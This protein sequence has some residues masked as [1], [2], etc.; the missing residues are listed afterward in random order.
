MFHSLFLKVDDSFNFRFV[1][2]FSPFHSLL[3]QYWECVCV[4]QLCRNI[5]PAY[6]SFS[7]VA[8][9]LL[10]R[11]YLCPGLKTTTK[12][13]NFWTTN[14]VP[15]KSQSTQQP[16]LC[17]CVTYKELHEH[18]QE[19]QENWTKNVKQKQ[20]QDKKRQTVSML[21]FVS[22]FQSFNFQLYTYRKNNFV[23]HFS[24]SLCLFCLEDFVCWDS[25][26]ESEKKTTFIRADRLAWLRLGNALNSAHSIFRMC[27]CLFDHWLG[28]V[29]VSG[30][31]TKLVTEMLVIF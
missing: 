15:G 8:L 28:L 12:M 24:L 30:C 14:W 5:A 9:Q 16:C 29:F 20:T 19:C 17:E 21:F 18:T 6:Y 7:V 1:F 11:K 13:Y 22:I 2:I 4:F 31:V 25:Q 3:I 27:V 26:L 10:K 23:I